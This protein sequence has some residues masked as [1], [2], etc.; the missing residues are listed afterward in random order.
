MNADLE[1]PKPTQ[2]FHDAYTEIYG[3]KDEKKKREQKSIDLVFP[4]FTEQNLLDEMENTPKKKGLLSRLFKK[5]RAVLDTPPQRIP[6]V[7]ESMDIPP[8]TAP[9]KASES[10]F[11]KGT[12]SKRTKNISFS[13]EEL[14]EAAR[15]IEAMD[16]QSIKEKERRPKK[17]TVHDF[18]EEIKFGGRK[19]D[20]NVNKKLVSSEN[21][22]MLPPITLDE[23]KESI[24]EKRK[25]KQGARDLQYVYEQKHPNETGGFEFLEK[26]EP[27]EK[28][29]ELRQLEIK[30]IP[31]D[32][33][34][35]FTTKE[36]VKKIKQ[37]T[38]KLKKQKKEWKSWKEKLDK[39]ERRIGEK[40]KKMQ[41]MEQ[42]LFKKQDDVRLYEPRLAELHRKQDAILEKE[43]EI[44]Q[45]QEDVHETETRLKAEEDAIVKKIKQIEKKEEIIL[46]ETT[47][48]EKDRKHLK[49]KSGELNNILKKVED[50]QKT[51]KR[52][53]EAL[54]ER[55]AIVRKKEAMITQ[56]VASAQ[57]LKKTAEKLKDVEEMYERMK[58]RLREAHMKH[59]DIFLRRA[60]KQ[61]LSL[62]AVPL[63]QVFQMKHKEHKEMT[64]DAMS[65][66]I[67]N[68][69][70][71]TKQ[72]IFEKHYNDANKSMNLLLG[73]YMQ[74][75]D[76]N[77]RKKEI[78]YEILG[79][80]NMLKLELLE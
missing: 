37:C 63:E 36:D 67:T 54:E 79:L 80:K 10:R 55:E 28:P 30:E 43:R 52:K 62:K 75:S 2:E 65:G 72:L 50:A 71:A 17:A 4:A 29:A 66:D 25:M 26:I 3:K 27:V 12:E 9:E 24:F 8:I 7:L 20:R 19:V 61:E 39:H 53:A 42:E 44:I 74:I 33:K 41:K 45:R 40:M 21:S 16:I 51:L 69:I 38:E 64:K 48:L 22:Q 57:K 13:D 23:R 59:T 58:K 49:E 46:K 56:E 68:L 73:K 14:E 35:K 34:K 77:P 18:L 47:N 5:N 6:S 31:K 32:R 76:S 60:P 78:Y 15:Q 70:T 1:A 11:I